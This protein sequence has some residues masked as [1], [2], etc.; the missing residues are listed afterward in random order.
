MVAGLQGLQPPEK[1][2]EDWPLAWDEM[3]NMHLDGG[4]R[5][6]DADAVSQRKQPDAWAIHWGKRCLLVREF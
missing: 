5:H 1:Q 3:A 6:A 4:V 2:I